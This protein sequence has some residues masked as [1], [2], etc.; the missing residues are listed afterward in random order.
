MVMLI[1]KRRFD[2]ECLNIH[3][4]KVLRNYDEAKFN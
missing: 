1:E 3:A 2:F 4:E